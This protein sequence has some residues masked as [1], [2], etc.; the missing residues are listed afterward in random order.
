MSLINELRKAEAAFEAAQ[1]HLESLKSNPALKSLKEFEDELRSV[2]GKYNM[3]LI[4]VNTLLDPNYK[5]PKPGASTKPSGTRGKTRTGRTYTNPHT[6]ERIDYLG[7][8]NK[9]LEEWR[10]KWGAE[11]VKGWGVLNK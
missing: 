10:E 5:A 3:S 4:D 2:M 1:A 11:E 7:G 9:Q 8:V 6:G